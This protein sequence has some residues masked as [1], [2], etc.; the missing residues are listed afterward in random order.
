GA[1]YRAVA[2]QL[3]RKKIDINDLSALDNVLK[4][5]DFR[6]KFN[7]GERTYILNGEDITNDLRT[8][9]V[10]NFA[11]KVSALA[12][13]REKLVELQRSLAQGLNAVFEGRDMGT[14]VFPD[15]FLKIY[16]TGRD[17]VRAKRRFDELKAKYP[18]ACQNLTM[19]KVLKDLHE[20]DQF[21]MN[22]PI[23][24]LKKAEDAFEI[25]TSD[26]SIE[27]VVFKIL[28]CRDLASLARKKKK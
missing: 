22:R 24:P 16:L 7:R 20:R 27:E 5:F 15:A 26:L 1:M 28:E 21:D 25:D 23:S 11:S 13:V 9:E 6:I 19:E 2:L 17:D 4:N 3:L 8:E 10:S 18:D 14:V 12:Q